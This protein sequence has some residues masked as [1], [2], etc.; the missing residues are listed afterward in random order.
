[1]RVLYS[2]N[3]RGYEAEC[4]N[5]E[6]SAASDGRV[7]FIPFNHSRYIDPLRITDSIK[8]DRLHRAQDGDLLNLYGAVRNAI[9]THAINALIVANCPPYH[10]DFLRTLDVYKV[11]FSADDPEATY[12]INIPYLH[13][14]QHVFF[15]DPAYSRDLDMADKMR[16]AGMVNADWLPISVF[17]FE[18]DASSDEASVSGRTR[19][20]DIIYVGSFWRQ[21]VETLVRV[22][23]AFGRRFRIYGFFRLKHNL[24]LNVAHQLGRW[25]RPLSF[26]QR[27]ALYQRAKIG[28]NI[29]WN[30]FGLGNQRL[31]QLPANGVMQISDCVSHLDR[32]FKV[33]DEVVGYR[34]AEE[35]I[36]KLHY[37][38]EHDA[39][40]QAIARAGYR[41]TMA[42]YRFGTVTR[43][44]AELIRAGMGRIGWSIARSA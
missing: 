12:M 4:W 26:E 19:D 37:Y 33:D 20:I 17:D 18:C 13:A 11:L 15:V 25:V 34:S 44:A 7:T 21:K 9:Q 36:E 30:E 23:E 28:F 43:R 24:Y 10:P 42:D 32:I 41:R 1:M 31:Y 35:L 27:V 22:N 8:L 16:Y 6:I 38:L 5:R 39:E 2:F 40:R 14:Y 29:H 3:K